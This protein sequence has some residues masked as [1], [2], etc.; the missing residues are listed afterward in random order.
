MNP[1]GENTHGEMIVLPNG[2]VA[3]IDGVPDKCDHDWSG[4]VALQSASGKMIYWYTYRQWASLCT[5]ARRKLVYDHHTQIDDPIVM[6]T[7]SCRKCKKIFEPP[8]F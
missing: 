4:D 2:T 3:F 1:F 7:G 5:D 8:L 6:E